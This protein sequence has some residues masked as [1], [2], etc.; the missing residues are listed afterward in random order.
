M[1][2]E[3]ADSVRHQL[4]AVDVAW[5]EVDGELLVLDLRTSGYLSINATGKELWSR[6]LDGATQ[7]E[8]ATALVETHGIDEQQAHRDVGAFIDLLHDR[9]L[10]D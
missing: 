9:Q 6:L 4:R 2:G 7:D 5:R 8:L 3:R 10:L 1:T